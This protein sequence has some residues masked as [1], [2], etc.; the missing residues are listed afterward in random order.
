MIMILI[1]DL[2]PGW[3]QR[4]YSSSFAIFLIYWQQSVICWRSQFL[5]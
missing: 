4:S 2:G 1:M 3:H 5:W